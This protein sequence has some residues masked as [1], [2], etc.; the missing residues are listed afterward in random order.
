MND[1]VA[2]K[3]DCTCADGGRNAH[4][5]VVKQVPK[6]QGDTELSAGK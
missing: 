4:D 2:N 6:Q 1:S 5:G 3:M